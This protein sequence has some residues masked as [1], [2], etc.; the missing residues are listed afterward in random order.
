MEIFIKFLT[1]LAWIFGSLSLAQIVV[2]IIGMMTYDRTKDINSI[3]SGYR[4]TFP[5]KIPSIIFIISIAW[6]IATW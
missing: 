3:L 2:Q 5:I 4:R 6:I 1:V